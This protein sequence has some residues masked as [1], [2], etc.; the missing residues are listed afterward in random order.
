MAA[1]FV[2]TYSDI[3]PFSVSGMY[4]ISIRW[5]ID[6]FVVLLSDFM[7]NFETVPIWTEQNFINDYTSPDTR[8]WHVIYA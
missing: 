7:M 2:K 1:E 4:S 6:P 3:L 8:R 5:P